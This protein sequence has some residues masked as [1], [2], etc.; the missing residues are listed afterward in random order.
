MATRLILECMEAFLCWR[1]LL[2]LRGC[3]GGITPPG[4]GR[5]AS[6]AFGGSDEA[7]D[8]AGTLRAGFLL[9]LGAAYA[10]GNLAW[11]ALPW[12]NFDE[13]TVR[14]FLNVRLW[15]K[16]LGALDREQL[17]LLVQFHNCPHFLRAVLEAGEGTRIRRSLLETRYEERGRF[18]HSR[19]TTT[20][21]RT[22][23][24]GFD[25]EAQVIHRVLSEE[26]ST[27]SG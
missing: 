16:L 15:G 3:A 27:S 17:R 23:I 10:D 25:L 14:D 11:N 1:T 9:A 8:I 24:R 2:Q 5:R 18:I 20:Y 21:V 6:E 19:T 26:E 12:A 22:M 13:G 7:G 4:A